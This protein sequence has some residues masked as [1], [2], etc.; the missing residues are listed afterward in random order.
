MTALLPKLEKPIFRQRLVAF[1][2]AGVSAESGLATFRDNEGLW[3]MTDVM[4]VATPQ[5][6]D[7]NPQYVLDF[8]NNLRVQLAEAVPNDAHIL[9]SELQKWHD[10]TIITQ[11]IDNLHESAGSKDVI[12]L[13][14]ELTKVTSSVNR[15]DKECIMEWQPNEPIKIG[16]LANDGS[17]LRPYVTWFGEYLSSD[18]VEAAKNAL[19]EADILLVIGTSLKVFPAS[20]MW[21]YTQSEIPK[22]LIDPNFETNDVPEGFSFINDVA[23]SGMRTFVQELIKLNEPYS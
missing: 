10:V 22:Y 16:D 9:L 20:Q 23:T 12:H 8:Y 14:G 21:K 18:E 6:F 1:T 15:L 7:K 13:H 19:R 5:A 17:Q 11:N 4:S 2:G 3:K